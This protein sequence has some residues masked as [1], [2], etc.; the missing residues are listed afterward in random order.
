MRITLEMNN[1]WHENSFAPLVLNDEKYRKVWVILV[2]WSDSSKF[3]YIYF[4]F[5]YK[6][7][8]KKDSL[9][10]PIYRKL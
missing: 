1:L 7:K 9:H 10:N 5:I 8:K 6:K 2:K 4:R 3:S